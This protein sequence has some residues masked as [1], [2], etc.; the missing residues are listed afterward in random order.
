LSQ[1]LEA[2]VPAGKDASGIYRF[3]LTGSKGYRNLQKIVAGNDWK[4]KEFFPSPAEP[5]ELLSR[6]TG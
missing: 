4:K 5:V 1:P 3:R 6:M 2:S